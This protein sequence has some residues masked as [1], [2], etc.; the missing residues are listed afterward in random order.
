MLSFC[1][2]IAG[3]DVWIGLRLDVQYAH[4]ATRPLQ[5][6]DTSMESIHVDEGAVAQY[7]PAL[8]PVP[9]QLSKMPAAQKVIIRNA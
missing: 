1:S 3:I 9:H 7:A 2:G 5:F 8:S 4:N 6:G